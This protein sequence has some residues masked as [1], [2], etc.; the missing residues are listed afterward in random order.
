M[1]IAPSSGSRTAAARDGD[2]GT[3]ARGSRTAARIQKPVVVRV[4]LVGRPVFVRALRPLVMVL[5][6]G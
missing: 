3:A 1:L 4:G 5:P 6:A 2:V